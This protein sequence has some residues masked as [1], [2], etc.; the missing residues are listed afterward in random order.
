MRLKRSATEIA[1]IIDRFLA[2]SSLYP[3]EWNDFVECRESGDAL[4]Y[5]RKRCDELDP[6]VNSPGE[7][8]VAAIAELHNIV[9]QLREIATQL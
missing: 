8:D 9:K 2:G 4:E 7:Q 5:F 1:D 6:L 3:Q